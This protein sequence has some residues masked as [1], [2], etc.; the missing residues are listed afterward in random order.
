VSELDGL[1]VFV[2]ICEEGSITRAGDRL[3]MPR[4]TVSRQLSRLEEDLG[5]RLVHR[6][7]RRLV[8]SEAGQELYVRAR[9]VVDDARAAREAVRRQDDVPRGRL[10]VSI[11]ADLPAPFVQILMDFVLAHPHIQAEI[12]GTARHVDLVAEGFDVALRGGASQDPSLIARRLLR[13]DVRVIGSR[14][15]LE[16]RGR[17]LEA[18]DLIDHDCVRNLTRGEV[19]V[20]HWPLL[21][22]G[23]VAVSGRIVCDNLSACV[24]AVRSG[25]GLGFLPLAM[26][27]DH[28]DLEVLLEEQVGT[29]GDVSAV[30]AERA[31]MQPKVRAFVDFVV[32]AFRERATVEGS[33]KAAFLGGGDPDPGAQ[34]WGS[35]RNP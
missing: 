12:H 9:R 29:T 7:T 18:A 20:T 4:S 30:Y 23:R 17:P 15:Y 2:A 8:L 14:G 21:D 6:T 35:G 1:D 27:A 22:G 31:L 19:P 33:W 32:E 13:S 28:R 11:P 16:R 25:L 24:Q 3:G 26:V 34:M 10:R 5:V